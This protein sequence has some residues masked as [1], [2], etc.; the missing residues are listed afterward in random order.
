MF[1]LDQCTNYEFGSFH[2]EH[3]LDKSCSYGKRV[4][5]S[6]CSHTFD[7]ENDMQEELENIDNDEGIAPNKA[8]ISGH[9][10]NVYQCLQATLKTNTYKQPPNKNDCYNLRSK[11][12]PLTLGEAQ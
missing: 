11:G 6:V 5:R 4:A 3:Q 10:V 7:A 1:H 2:K 9:V 8:S 12:A